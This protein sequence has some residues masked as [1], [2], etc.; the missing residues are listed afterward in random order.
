MSKKTWFKWGVILVGST[1]AALNIGAC[2]ADFV[3]QNA[4][5]SVV[6]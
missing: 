6:A 5:L 2:L 3:L 4:I 1:V